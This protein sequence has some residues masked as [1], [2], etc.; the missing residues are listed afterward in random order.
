VYARVAQHHHEALTVLPRLAA[1]VGTVGQ[2]AVGPV[3]NNVQTRALQPWPQNIP[4][5]LDGALRVPPVVDYHVETQLCQSSLH[6]RF[7]V[8]ARRYDLYVR[9]QGEGGHRLVYVDAVDHCIGAE[10]LAPQLDAS[11]LLDPH[12]QDVRGRLL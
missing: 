3:L 12:F 9:I 8:G 4:S 11:A 7:A 5:L 2:Q 6:R 1:S 10:I